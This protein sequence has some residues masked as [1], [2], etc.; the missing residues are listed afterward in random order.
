M[1]RIHPKTRALLNEFADAVHIDRELNQRV[2]MKGSPMQRRIDLVA[3]RA[4]LYMKKQQEIGLLKVG[5]KGKIRAKKKFHRM[6]NDFMKTE[7]NIPKFFTEQV[8]TPKTD[9]ILSDQSD[10]RTLPKIDPSRN[11]KVS[12]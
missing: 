11:T 3:M 4:T 2:F 8:H 9:I 7:K 10:V 5:K 1:R 12:Q 6:M